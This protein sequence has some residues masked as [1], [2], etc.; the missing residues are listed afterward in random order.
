VFS[1]TLPHILRLLSST[2][3][4]GSRLLRLGSLF[5]LVSGPRSLPPCHFFRI[6]GSP[7]FPLIFPPFF[8]LLTASRSDMSSPLSPRAVFL[9]LDTVRPLVTLSRLPDEASV[10]H[11]DVRPPCLRNPQCPRTHLCPPCPPI[12]PQEPPGSAWPVPRKSWMSLFVILKQQKPLPVTSVLML[13]D[14]KELSMPSL[15]QAPADREQP[16]PT[17]NCQPRPQNP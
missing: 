1:D 14:W 12:G 9:D 15:A 16:Q 13:S 10:H 11:D 6:F 8:P 7:D 2:E 17:V 3:K 5:V 4:P